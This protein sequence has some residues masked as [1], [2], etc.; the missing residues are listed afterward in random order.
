LVVLDL[1]ER[2][3]GLLAL[4]VIW[5]V[6]LGVV[7]IVRVT[8][9]GTLLRVRTKRSETEYAYLPPLEMREESESETD[10]RAS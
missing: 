6:S 7:L 3:P 9:P 8:R 5:M 2:H 4:S 1:I 10:L